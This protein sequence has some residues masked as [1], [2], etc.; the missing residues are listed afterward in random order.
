MHFRA[1]LSAATTLFGDEELP[2]PQPLYTPVNTATGK[3]QVCLHIRG[4]H[5]QVIAV[6][7][8]LSLVQEIYMHLPMLTDILAWSSTS[9]WTCSIGK[10]IATQRFTQ[11]IHPFV[12]DYTAKMQFLMYAWGAVIT[13]FCALQMLAGE[14]E[15]TPNLNIVVPSGSFDVMQGFILESLKYQRVDAVTCSNYAFC[16]V[17][18]TFGKYCHGRLQITLCEAFSNN[19]YEVITCSPTT[20]DMT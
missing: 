4:S 13:G 19:V 15:G 10:S 8:T 18:K 14:K 2:S 17:V 5:V 20:A 12:G 1:C 7:M 6:L 16:T 3:L 11:I 9:Q